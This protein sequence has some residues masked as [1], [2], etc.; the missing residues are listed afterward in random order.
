[1]LE[2]LN[3]KGSLNILSDSEYVNIKT[4]NNLYLKIT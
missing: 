4:W 2:E 3:K 1:M